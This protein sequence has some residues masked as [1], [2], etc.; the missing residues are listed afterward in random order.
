MKPINQT[1][2]DLV[3]PLATPEGRPQRGRAK[4]L[5][6]WLSRAFASGAPVE[7]LTPRMR[8]D[9]GI[10]AGVAARRAAARGPLIR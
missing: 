7:R 2:F 6:A 10:D 3:T 8:R 9:A 5:L 4:G 1:D